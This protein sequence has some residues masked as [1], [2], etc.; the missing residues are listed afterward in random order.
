MCG[1]I[2]RLVIARNELVLVDYKTHPQ[3]THTNA[4]ELAQAYV[5][6]MRLYGEGARRLWPGKHLKLLLLFTAC[7]AIIEV[8]SAA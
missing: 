2:D 1:I 8:P 6:Q 4:T 7:R 5:R 3:A